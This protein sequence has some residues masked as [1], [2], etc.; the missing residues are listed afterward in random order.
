MQDIRGLLP[1]TKSDT[2]KAQAL[3]SLGYPAVAPV[4]PELVEWLQ[5]INWP[6]AQVLEPFLAGIGLPLLPQVRRVLATEDGTWKYWVLSCL[7]ARSSALAS[8]LHEELTR[9]ASAPTPAEVDE[10]LDTQARAILSS[11]AGGTVNEPG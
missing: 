11:V 5:D 4:L 8:A 9:L 1:Q 2:D 7:V 6:V 3:V 10:E